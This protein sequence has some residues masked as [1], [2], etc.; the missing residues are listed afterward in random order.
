M[1]Q[2]DVLSI[3]SHVWS[4][5]VT[6][7]KFHLD[8]P[9]IHTPP[10]QPL[11]FFQVFL[12]IS[13][14]PKSPKKRPPLQSLQPSLQAPHEKTPHS[15]QIVNSWQYCTSMIHPRDI[16]MPIGSPKSPRVTTPPTHFISQLT[17]QGKPHGDPHYMK[18][19]CR[20][21]LLP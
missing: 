21:T 3:N 16:H 17:P 4:I 6:N 5:Q 11:K 10:S 19:Y 13:S 9:W 15:I 14:I 20:L 12:S 1:L 8:R 2:N 7:H 18:P